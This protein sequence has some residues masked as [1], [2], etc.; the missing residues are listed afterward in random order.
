MVTLNQNILEIEINGTTYVPKGSEKSEVVEWTGEKSL[1]SRMIG[2]PVIVRDGNDG[3]NAGIGSDK[4]Y[5]N[6]NPCK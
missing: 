5:I 6:G 1:A 4:I 3:V 2:N